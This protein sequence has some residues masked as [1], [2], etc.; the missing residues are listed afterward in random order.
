M[1]NPPDIDTLNL[2]EVV[3]FPVDGSPSSLPDLPKR[4][5]LRGLIMTDDSITEVDLT[6]KRTANSLQDSRQT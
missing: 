3:S 2:D 4:L 1:N 6:R 5:R